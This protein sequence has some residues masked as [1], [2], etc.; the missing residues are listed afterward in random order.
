MLSYC[1]K[2]H[3]EE[4]KTDPEINEQRDLLTENQR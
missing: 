3:R 1:V 4:C 2:Q